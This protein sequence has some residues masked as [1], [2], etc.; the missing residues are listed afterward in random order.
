MK[1]LS[2]LLLSATV[3]VSSPVAAQQAVSGIA[4]LVKAVGTV[5]GSADGKAWTKAERGL[6]L[7]VGYQLRTAAVSS[8]VLR[9]NDGTILNL[10]SD[11]QIK[12]T[13]A[14]AADVQT[15]KLTFAIKTN[16]AE[17]FKFTAPTAV[18]AIKG[19]EGEFEASADE[20]ELS[21]FSSDRTDDI[22]DLTLLKTNQTEKIGIGERVRFGREGRLLRRLLNAQERKVFTDRLRTLRGD[23]ENGMKSIMKRREQ[24]QKKIQK[25]RGLKSDNARQQ[26]QLQ[27]RQMAKL[28]LRLQR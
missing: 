10:K 2:A 4:I 7:L 17:P 27:Q 13:G 16:P 12:L 14:R 3:L 11:S 21:I 24:M 20:A 6:D 8:C 18:G 26:M 9:F 22:A 1:I 23:S 5:E 28:R 15:G 25:Q 19:T